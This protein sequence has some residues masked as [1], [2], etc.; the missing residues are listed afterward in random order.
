MPLHPDAQQNLDERAALGARNVQELSVAEG[1]AQ[2]LRL[3][4]TAPRERVPLIREFEIADA[5]GTIPL[6]LY[7]PNEDKILPIIVFFHGGGWVLGNLETDDAVC[8][9]WANGVQALVV[10]VNYHHAPEDKFPAA[11]EDAYT[12]T[13]WVSEHA[14]EIGGDASR[15]AVAGKSAGGNLA[16]ATTLM[17]RDRG[18]PP[19]AF[20][21]LWVPVLDHNLETRSYH[22]NAEGYGLTRADMT[23]FWNQYLAHPSD[24][25]N[26]Y[27]SPLRAKDL[28]K[29]PPA[30]VVIAQY[31]P[32]R[33]E[34]V[35]YAEKLRA[36]GVA[37]ESRCFEGMI[38]GFVGTQ[39][40]EDAMRELRR[41]LDV[42]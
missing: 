17:A 20:Q 3:A 11:A 26:P 15:L 35:A 27:A 32:L 25:E 37:V 28:S 24:G 6:R 42:K 22:D 12:A 16:A 8:R 5:Y 1:R 30:F 38:H 7:Y 9:Q 41:A 36:A 34:A 21:L 2:S 23:W 33:D 18:V 40:L 19:I 14:A 39:A 4:A 31:D 29:L 13:R 10:S